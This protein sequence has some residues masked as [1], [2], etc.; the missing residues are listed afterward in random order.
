MLEAAPVM[1][2]Y[3]MKRARMKGIRDPE[4]QRRYFEEV[5]A[6][7]AGNLVALLPDGDKES[8]RAHVKLVR[9]A[10][11]LLG[12]D[13]PDGWR[14]LFERA[15]H[16]HEASIKPPVQPAPLTSIYDQVDKLLGGRI[17]TQPVKDVLKRIMMRPNV[18]DVAVWAGSS[19]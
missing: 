11:V 5:A 9:A 12:R 6:R 2:V 13:K 10:D 4:G 1:W 15:L 8:V 17:D 3:V 16:M 14:E 18:P 7:I 19:H